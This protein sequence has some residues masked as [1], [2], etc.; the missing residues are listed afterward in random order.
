MTLTRKDGEQTLGTVS[1]T[2]PAGLAAMLS[3]VPLCAEAQANAGTCSAASAIGH[4]TAKAGIGDKPVEL[5]EEGK[6]QDPVYLTGPYD[7]APFGLSFVVPAQAGPFN[8][9][10]VVVRAKIEVNPVTAQVTIVSDPMP[11]RLQNIKLDVRS[12]Q[13]TVDREGFMFN[14][15]NCEPT[16]ISGTIG[17]EEGASEAVSSRFEAADCASLPFKP[18]FKALTHAKHSRKQGAYLHI[19]IAKKEGEANIRSVLVKLPKVLVARETTLKQACGEEQFGKDPAA[20]PAGSKVGTATV[21]TPVLPVA[22]TGTAYYVSHGGAA[23]PD[24][25]L[26][27]Q[28]DGVTV[29]LTGNTHVNGRTDV[30][31]SD[32][33]SAPDVPFG[34]FELV[35]PEQSNSAIGGNG[36][37][38]YRTVTKKKRVRVREHG[39]WVHRVKKVHHKVRRRLTMPTTITGQNGAVIKQA[40]KM[41]VTGCAKHKAKGATRKRH[42][43]KKG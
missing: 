29:V 24:L 5:P 25:D 4:V 23:Y 8:L 15:T 41:A 30:T 31:S 33:K 36:D 43:H 38:C 12:V 37:L 22:L 1:M 34:R 9:G 14:P 16:S 18:D 17:S 35:L 3:K 2:M 39:K 42:H 20:C 32:F 26:V 19:V 11:T 40:T 13:V 6:P 10:T 21:Y 7:G 27:L 28:G